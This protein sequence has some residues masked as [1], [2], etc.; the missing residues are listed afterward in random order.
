[1]RTVLLVIFTILVIPLYLVLQG[2]CWRQR[3]EVRRIAPAGYV[4]PASFG[5]VLAMGNRGLLSDYLFLKGMNFVGERFVT[6]EAMTEE[7]WRYFIAII[8]RVTDL[9]PYFLDP[10]IMAEG[11]L[12]WDAGKVAEANQLLE[13]GR[14]HRKNQWRIPFYMGFNYF[15]FLKDYAKGAEYIMEASRIAGSP[16]FLAT[17]GGRLSYYGGKTRTGILFL[18]EIMAETKDPAF[19]AKMEIRLAAMERAASLE[20]LLEKFKKEKGRSPKSLNDLVAAGYLDRLPKEPYGGEW[21]LLPS[22]RVFS[23]SRFVKNEKQH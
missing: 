18:K 13:K 2:A 1:M 17:L 16:P 19:R 8:D 9:D 14:K 23:T 7:D 6:Q 22:G 10:Y 12:T 5:R 4:M 15:Y 20:D 21:I 3:E 11:I